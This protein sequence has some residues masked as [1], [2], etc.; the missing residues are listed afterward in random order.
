MKKKLYE[1][2]VYISLFLTN[3]SVKINSHKL[4]AFIIWLNVRKLKIIRSNSKNP[5]KILVFPK[6]NGTEDLI[7]SFKNKKSNIIFFLLPRNFLKKIFSNFFDK[8][9]ETDYFTKLTKLKDIN[10]KNAYINFLTLTFKYLE[11]F[12]HLDGFI[13]FNLFYYAEKYFEE[14]CKNLNTKFIIIHKE[15]ALNISEEAKAPIIYGK[16]NNKSLSYKISVYS[17]SQKKILIK[18]KIANK[19]QI[20]VNGAPRSDYAFSL[21]KITPQKKIIVYYLIEKNRSSN[22]LSSY[23]KSNWNKLYNQTLQYLFE[24]AKKNQNIQIILKGKIGAHTK[25]QFTKNTLPKNCYYVDGGAGH[26]FL[27][28]ASVVIAFN[29]MSVFETI[30]SNRNLIIPNFN[31]ESKINKNILLKIKNKKYFV[32][33]KKDF[34]QKIKFYLNLKYKNKKLSNVDIKTLRYFLGNTDGT[35]GSKLKKFLVKSLSK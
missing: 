7:E 29:S 33:S 2:F 18:S 28:N 35:S 22:E 4:C 8:S 12:I 15:S 31:N 14:V 6:S 26:T 10:K 27:K 17:E 13:S 16:Y 9:Y 30:A 1:L 25:D 21:R 20:V 24:F 3:V 23:K 19:K 5:K 32:K 34:D 11:N